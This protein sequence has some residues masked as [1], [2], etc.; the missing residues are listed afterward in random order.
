MSL[1]ALDIPPVATRRPER[2]DQ[3]TAWHARAPYI[4]VV[5]IA[6]IAGCV[7]VDSLPVGGFYDDAFYVL[8]GKSIATGHGYRNLNLPGTPFA[9]HYPPGYPLFLALLW[10]VAP[11]FPGNVLLFKLANVAFLAVAAAFAYRLGRERMQLGVTAALIAVVAGTATTPALYLSSMVLSETM[12][13]ALVLPFLLWAESRLA[14]AETSPR[15]AILLGVGAGFLFL[16]RSQAIALVVAVTIV[17]A[18]RRRWRGAAMTAGAAAMIALPWLVWVAAHDGDIPSLMRG[19]YGSY[20]GWYVDGIRE[21]GAGILLGTLRRT[22]SDM[23][24]LVAQRLRPPSLPLLSGIS[25]L[26][27]LLLAICG[28]TRLARRAP[29]TL[30]FIGAYLAIAALWPFPPTRFLL[31]IWV[32]LML[33][34]ASGAQMLVNDRSPNVFW[35]RPRVRLTVQLVGGLVAAMLITGAVAYNIRGFM[36]RTWAVTEEA[37]WR[38]IAPKVAWVRASTDTS[39][40]IASDHD[41]GA[42]FLYT[43]R[44]A[45]PVT[46]FTAGEYVEPRSIATDSLVLRWLALRFKADYVLLS[47]SRLRPAAASISRGM[48]PLEDGVHQ[49][50]PWAFATRPAAS[51]LSS[52]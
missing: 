8:L 44:R 41:E 24:Q 12:F 47:S 2:P 42:I 32:I 5:V 7:A 25:S 28:A 23:F 1:P 3:T 35:H 9:T 43:G 17:Y 46:T 36:H 37:S 27:V 29:V 4:V 40:V 11:S 50:V 45:V 20:F 33:L 21:H 19:D 26:C 51:P 16:V 52:R 18:V 38:W 6:L 14:Q 22:L 31:G 15:T 10:W 30:T 39:A 34:L 13:L 48:L 49:I